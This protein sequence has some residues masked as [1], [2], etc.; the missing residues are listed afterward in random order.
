MATFTLP[1][2]VVVEKRKAHSPWI[3]FVWSAHSVLPDAPE[4]EAGTSLGIAGDSELFFA[5]VALLEAH[6]YETE[7]YRS[8][9]MSGK[10]Q[11]WV[12]TRPR[13]ETHVPELIQVTCDPT[14]GEGFTETGWETVNIVPMPEP[15]QVAL[16]AF[17]EE[18]HVERP[19]FKRKRDRADPEAL[20]RFRKGPD[21]D[22]DMREKGTSPDSTKDK[23]S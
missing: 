20:A 23:P 15:I 12:V 1:V 2:G 8:N 16:M 10:P 21:R 5:G 13:G 6:T 18:H 11:L 9:F 17:I 7:Q 19:F 22:R 14:E 3:D 4:A